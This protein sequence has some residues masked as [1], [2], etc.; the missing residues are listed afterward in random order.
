M[1]QIFIATISLV[2]CNFYTS[3]AQTYIEVTN[4]KTPNNSVVQDTY[5]LTSGDLIYNSTQL[6]ALANDLY[7]N[8]NGAELIEAPSYKYNCHAYAWH[9]SEGGSKVWIGRYTVT[10]EDIYWTDG[11]YTE[12]SESAATK[13]SYHQ[14][15]N[16]S[17]IR[18]NSTWYQSKWGASS[19][20]KHHPN[21]V[22]SI[23]QP[24]KT[25]KYYIRTSSS[26][27]ISISG[28]GSINYLSSGTYT[29]SPSLSVDWW[30]RKDN[31]NPNG[32]MMVYTGSS[33]TLLSMKAGSASILP[34]SVSEELTADDDDIITRQDINGALYY[35]QARYGNA[36]SLEFRIQASGNA[37]L[38]AIT[39]RSISLVSSEELFV[40]VFPNPAS[41]QVTIDLTDNVN[42]ELTSILSLPSNTISSIEPIYAVR[43][44]DVYGSVVYTGEKQGKTFDMPVSSLP[45]GIYTII[46]SDGIRTQQ[47]KFIVKH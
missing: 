25:K 20:V 32:A 14:D 36:V 12:T 37:E 46:I 34:R 35:L 40:S 30:L 10:A 33:L 41:S 44:V 18:L 21:D 43:I 6:S 19:L 4:V 2:L 39:P 26:T 22:P 13:V 45:N 5:S 11:S 23:Y 42:G 3:I 28:P 15:G 1:K 38:V 27:S 24:S 29:V 8:Y 47:K 31:G 9:V 7:Y 17:A 16:H